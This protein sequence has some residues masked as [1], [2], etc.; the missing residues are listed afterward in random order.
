[1][2]ADRQG[3]V[4]TG[5]GRRQEGGGRFVPLALL[6]CILHLSGA[7]C[8][9]ENVWSDTTHSSMNDAFAVLLSTFKSRFTSK[10]PVPE[11]NQCRDD[12][13]FPIGFHWQRQN[14]N[15]QEII[16]YALGQNWVITKNEH[17]AICFILW[18]SFRVQFCFVLEKSWLT[19]AC[20]K[21]TLGPFSQFC[22]LHSY[23]N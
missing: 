14:S 2:S 7:M 20:Q 23:C 10:G 9:Q 13:L 18:L 12:P 19:L 21:K 15:N 22:P 16:D 1:M 6:L 5:G 4:E 8:R 3:Q 11:L 17:L